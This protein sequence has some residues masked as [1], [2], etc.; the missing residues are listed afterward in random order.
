MFEDFEFEDKYNP[1]DVK[2]L[3]EFQYYCCP[4]C[5]SKFADKND[6]IKHVWEAHP[7]SQSTI[8]L[9]GGGDKENVKTVQ[10]VGNLGSELEEKFNPWDVNSLEEFRYYCCPEC[11]SKYAIKTYFIIHAVTLHSH[12]KCFIDGFDDDKAV[13]KTENAS[14]DTESTNISEKSTHEQN[15]GQKSGPKEVQFLEEDHLLSR[16]AVVSLP[17]LSDSIIRKYLEPNFS[18]SNVSPVHENIS[19]ICEKCGKSFSWKNNLNMHIKTV[20]E[21]VRFSQKGSM[22]QHVKSAHE[23]ILYTCDRCDKSFSTKLLLKIHV[24]KVHEYVRYYCEFCGKSFSQKVNL[25]THIKSVHESIRYNCDKCRKSF[26]QEA[27][28]NTHKKSAHE[29]VRYNCELC[30]KRFTQKGNLRIHLQSVHEKV[31]YNCVRC[32]KKF[33]AKSSLNLRIKSQHKNLR[34]NCDLCDKSFSQKGNLKIHI[35]GVHEKHIKGAHENVRFKCDTCDKSFTRK[36]NL[37]KHI[38]GA[39]ENV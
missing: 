38:Q 19:Y 8:E 16:Q 25:N 26:T 10:I 33:S 29:N 14:S 28:L 34:Y 20:H 32:D 11:P 1:W 23:N 30:D 7:E 31:Q 27:H 2:S 37:K 9:F 22:D 24:E 36:D 12:S 6:F 5:P 18:F 21:K 13:I 35:K 3:E 17:K 15:E 4:S 39:H